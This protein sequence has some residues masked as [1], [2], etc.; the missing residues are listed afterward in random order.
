MRRHFGGLISR[1]LIALR[2]PDAIHPTGQVR[3]LVAVYSERGNL[4]TL[5]ATSINVLADR[6]SEL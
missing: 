5:A 2:T 3:S 6:V 1:V 4:P